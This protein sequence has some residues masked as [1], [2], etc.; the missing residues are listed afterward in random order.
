MKNHRLLFVIMAVVFVM[1]TAIILFI[2]Q[3]TLF[4]DELRFIEEAISIAK[5]GTF[6][7]YGEYR[8]WEMPLT[9]IIY[10]V[11]YIFFG[12]NN[13]I[14][15]IR[16]FQ[17]LILII[18][19][20]GV[21]LI[22]KVLF[23]DRIA[24]LAAI[25]MTL[26]YPS[27]VS[28]HL[29]LLSEL[30]FTFFLV[31]SFVF[32][33][34]W[35]DRK[36]NIW[37]ILSILTF[38]LAAYTRATL[39]FIVPVFV[40]LA[41]YA[42]NMSFSKVLRYTLISA[43][44]FSVCLSPWWIRNY[45]VLGEYIPF[46]TSAS[47]NLYLGNNPANTTASIDWGESGVDVDEVKRIH[48]LKD[49]LR[50]SDAY[51]QKAKEYIINNP[52][53]FLKNAWLKFKRFWNFVSNYDAPTKQSLFFKMYNISLLLSWMPVFC[54]GTVSFWLNRKIWKKILPI[55]CL[56]AYYTFIHIVTIAS[57]RYRLPIEPFF[58]VMASD[59]IARIIRKTHTLNKEVKNHA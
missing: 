42:A 17:A 1:Y 50:I 30:L 40:L 15:A 13:F 28:Y 35:M 10:S 26:F 11:F 41:S 19:S 2:P 3:K 32:T 53:V 23:K 5:T 39:T 59:C 36:K 20:L 47:W 16:I 58:I 7:V 48:D 37:L 12:E 8:A 45:G 6:V 14:A 34:T 52:E 27:L 44:V 51:M 43:I 24:Y 29:T 4:P 38:S 33:Y 21:G 56:I 22:S 49:E 9:A 18:T 54:L 46:T 31:W 57:L 25:I 55:Y